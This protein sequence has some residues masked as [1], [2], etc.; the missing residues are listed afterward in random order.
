MI[1]PDNVVVIT[2]G[3]VRDPESPNDNLVKFSVARDYAGSEGGKSA[4]GYFDVVYWLNSGSS[5]A[6]WVKKQISAGNIKRGSQLRIMGRLTQE[7][8]AQ[9][10]STRSRVVITA[11]A[12]SYASSGKRAD[13]GSSTTTASSGEGQAAV[14]DF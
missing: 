4:T 10:G 12:I 14:R 2:G 7:R 5:N 9:D 6:D 1:D 13:E 3:L 8:W 11:E